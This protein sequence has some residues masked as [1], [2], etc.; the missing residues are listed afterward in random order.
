MPDHRK[1]KTGLDRPVLQPACCF[2]LPW[3]TVALALASA[4]VAPSLCGPSGKPVP[5]GPASGDQHAMPCG[6]GAGRRPYF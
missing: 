6:H 3:I 2:L 4:P 1:T 5:G